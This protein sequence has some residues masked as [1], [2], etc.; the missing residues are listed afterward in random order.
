MVV[1][2]PAVYTRA[3]F[4]WCSE[5]RGKCPDSNLSDLPRWMVGFCSIFLST[6]PFAES[7]WEDHPAGWFLRLQQGASVLKIF[8]QNYKSSL[9]LSSSVRHPGCFVV[10]LLV[11][12]LLW[13]SLQPLCRVRPW[14]PGRRINLQHFTTRSTRKMLMRSGCCSLGGWVKE[15]DF[16]KRKRFG[17]KGE[18]HVPKRRWFS[19]GFPFWTYGHLR[20]VSKVWN[21]QSPKKF[22]REACR[23]PFRWGFKVLSPMDRP[24]FFRTVGIDTRKGDTLVVASDSSPLGCPLWK[25]ERFSHASKSKEKGPLQGMKPPFSWCFLSSGT[26]VPGVPYQ[27]PWLSVQNPWKYQWFWGNKSHL[28]QNIPQVLGRHLSWTTT[29]WGEQNPLEIP[30]SWSLRLFFWTPHPGAFKAPLLTSR[31][32]RRLPATW[33]LF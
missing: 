30:L 5:N 7:F 10:A 22:T 23:H 11:L 16:P 14:T 19:K 1:C 4:T 32:C 15:K 9:L 21:W 2:F 13:D 25:D 12:C 29:L 28:I 33:Q 20:N 27:L 31:R 18:G 8:W 24:C 6:H 3:E 17:P 26:G